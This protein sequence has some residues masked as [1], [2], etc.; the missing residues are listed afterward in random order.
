MP[1][2]TSFDA[3]REKHG[4]IVYYEDDKGKAR[5]Q[6][7]TLAEAA[8]TKAK[9]AVGTA[10]ATAPASPTSA[11]GS[12]NPKVAPAPVASMT[13]AGNAA[14][15]EERTSAAVGHG[16]TVKCNFA[17]TPPGAEVTVDGRYVGSTPS[18]LGLATGTHVIVVSMDGYSRWKRE[19]AVTAGSELTV[20]AVLEKVR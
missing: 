5:R 17:S 1:K 11:T 13:S 16:E 6:L 7:Y 15:V 19:L 10:T 9:P 2:G 20:N 18:V 14:V 4:I 3:R 12:E 8:T